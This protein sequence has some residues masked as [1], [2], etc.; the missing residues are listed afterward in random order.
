MKPAPGVDWRAGL[1]ALAKTL[2]F[3]LDACCEAVNDGELYCYLSAAIAGHRIASESEAKESLAFAGAASSASPIVMLNRMDG[4]SRGSAPLFHY[5]VETDVSAVHEQDFNAWYN[6]EHLPGLVAVPG[7]IAAARYL[8]MSNSP[9]YIAAYDLVSP[10]VLER[11]EWLAIRNT[12]W[13]S[14]VRPNFRNPK[15]TLFRHLSVT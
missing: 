9:R 6:N 14:L 2:G 1:A 7:C 11:P 13:S 5:V 4:V 15:R 12:D 10:D 8:N 3:T